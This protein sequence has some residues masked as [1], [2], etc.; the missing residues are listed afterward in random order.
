MVVTDPVADFLT[1]IRNAQTANHS[2]VRI[3]YSKLKREI[4]RV[5]DEE[6]YIV[7]YAIEE[8]TPYDNIVIRLKYLDDEPV[9]TGM[10]R[11]SKPGQRRYFGAKEIPTVLNGYGVAVMSTSRGVMTGQKAEQEGVGGEYLCSIW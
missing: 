4:A 6:G 10:L 9:I 1:R 3:P 11:K 8:G 7:E 2:V 5:F